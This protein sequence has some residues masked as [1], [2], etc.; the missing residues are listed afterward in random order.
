MEQRKHFHINI[1][2]R[3]NHPIGSREVYVEN[4]DTAKLLFGGMISGLQLRIKSVYGD[5]YKITD[6]KKKFIY[7]QQ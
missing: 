1:K 2:T 3:G 6:N 5:V 7:R 4:L